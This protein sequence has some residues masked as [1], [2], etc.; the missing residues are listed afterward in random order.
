MGLLC[1]RVTSLNKR[2]SW[3]E[4]KG[5]KYIAKLTTEVIKQQNGTKVSNNICQNNEIA[6]LM[7]HV[8]IVT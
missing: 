7:H 4:W 8:L 6:L 2:L 5:N 1:L 3:Q